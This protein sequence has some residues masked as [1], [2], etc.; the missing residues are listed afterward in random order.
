MVACGASEKTWR[1]RRASMLAK[2]AR[3]PGRDLEPGLS[4]RSH[5]VRFLIVK[6]A[7]LQEKRPTQQLQSESQFFNETTT[8]GN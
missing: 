6:Q 8:S 7:E 4:A 2:V 1:G 3:R 5:P